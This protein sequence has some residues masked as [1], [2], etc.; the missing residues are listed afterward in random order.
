MLSA[1]KILAVAA[2]WY[3]IIFLE[4]MILILS[5]MPLTLFCTNEFDDL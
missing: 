1:L 2:L 3:I 5:L 4:D